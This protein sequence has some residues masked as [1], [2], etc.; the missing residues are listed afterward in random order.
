MV[1]YFVALGQKEVTLLRAFAKLAKKKIL[2]VL[3]TYPDPTWWWSER[4]ESAHS[5]SFAIF[6]RL[7]TFVQKEKKNKV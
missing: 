4:S 2:K 5:W 7:S 1:R 3:E 6:T